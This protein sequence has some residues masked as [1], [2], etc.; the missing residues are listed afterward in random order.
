M[1]EVESSDACLDECRSTDGCGFATYNGYTRICVLTE[2]CRQ[3]DPC[4][5]CVVAA[6]RN[7][8]CDDKKR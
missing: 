4:G 8:S 1:V 6:V 5:D 7:D 2:T 3:R